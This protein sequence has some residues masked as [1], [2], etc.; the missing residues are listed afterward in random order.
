LGLD[1]LPP[2]SLPTVYRNNHP[3]T[4]GTAVDYRFRYYF[5]SYD[6]HDTVAAAGIR[7]LADSPLGKL[8]REF[9]VHLNELV[10]RINP[11]RRQLADDDEAA[12]NACCLI[13]AMFEQVFRAGQV[14]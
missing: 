11:A 12:L 7:L 10:A 5:R 9:L 13:L 1:T 6:A 3:G 8:G 14:R 2:C 4:I